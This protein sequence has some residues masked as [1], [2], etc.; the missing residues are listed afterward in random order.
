MDWI[1]GLKDWAKTIAENPA[2]AYGAMVSGILVLSLFVNYQ[3]GKGWLH[4]KDRAMDA[5]DTYAGGVL[6]MGRMTERAQTIANDRLLENKT[7][8]DTIAAQK[9]LIELLLKK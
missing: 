8:R 4:E 7:L 2:A 3:V 1:R 5:K 6:E 9:V